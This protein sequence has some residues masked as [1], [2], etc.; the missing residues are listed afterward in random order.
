LS[1]CSKE[2]SIDLADPRLSRESGVASR[3]RRSA[4]LIANDAPAVRTAGLGIRIPGGFRH[5][6]RRSAALSRAASARLR[7]HSRLAP[8]SGGPTDGR[9]RPAAT[10]AQRR[11][12]AQGRFCPTRFWFSAVQGRRMVE[13]L[14]TE[15]C[16]FCG[17]SRVIS[18]SNALNLVGRIPREMAKLNHQKR[19]RPRPATTRRRRV[20][21][22]RAEEQRSRREVERW[23]R[24][25]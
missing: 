18:A 4:A 21:L 14:A 11:V 9:R 8:L 22:Q 24:S 5:D 10:A 2:R 1:H 6:F 20:N 7:R 15:I 16:N 17:R 13:S 19:H 23:R 12:H 3:L 25:A